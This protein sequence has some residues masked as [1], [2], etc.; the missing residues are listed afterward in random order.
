VVCGTTTF[1]EL[2]RSILI[3][4][5][6]F[7]NDATNGIDL[8]QSGDAATVTIATTDLLST[9]GCHKQVCFVSGV[10]SSTVVSPDSSSTEKLTPLPIHGFCYKYID[11]GM[12]Q[13]ENNNGSTATVL[14]TDPVVLQRTLASQ[15]FDTPLF[16]PSTK[17]YN[18]K[19]SSRGRTQ[20][21]LAYCSKKRHPYL[22]SRTQRAVLPELIYHSQILLE[23]IGIVSKDLN[24]KLWGERNVVGLVSPSSSREKNQEKIINVPS[25]PLFD[26]MPNQS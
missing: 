17:Q 15:V 11:R 10:N 16:P 2:I 21:A 12:Q 26:P 9:L 23:G 14:S 18:D 5:G 19:P 4:F 3:N 24:R 20:L 13:Q 6:L 8:K 1:L 25:I 22:S 7:D